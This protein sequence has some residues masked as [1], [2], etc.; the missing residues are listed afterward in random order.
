MSS[1]ISSGERLIGSQKDNFINIALNVI[2]VFSLCLLIVFSMFAF[3][4]IEGASMENSIFDS[5][6]CLVQRSFFNVDYND[7]ITI[8]TAEGD[9]EEH[10]IIKRAVGLGG[11]RLIFMR[12]SD[13]NYMELY[14]CRAGETTFKAVDERYIKEK[15]LVRPNSS[16][17]QL[18]SDSKRIL[19]YT[20][21]LTEIALNDILTDERYKDINTAV[22]EV[23]RGYVYFLGD[24]RNISRDSRYY[25]AMPL[26][27]VSSKVIKILK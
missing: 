4:P 18:L 6:T 7:I 13:R 25:G 26:P 20:P 22:I 23:P 19:A 14:R 1:E 12:T 15:M 27:A 8:D 21:K 17:N 3:I 11:D 9:G 24:N 5:Q 16:V 2:I 10:V